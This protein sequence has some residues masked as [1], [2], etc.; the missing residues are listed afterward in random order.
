M[1]GCDPV[2]LLVEGCS[3]CGETRRVYIN[4]AQSIYHTGEYVEFVKRF[5]HFGICDI[6]ELVSTSKIL[7]LLLGA[8]VIRA[9]LLTVKGTT[10][11]I[12]I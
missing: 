5:A 2:L 7:Q 6:L 9:I 10:N 11:Y 8:P 12:C 4:N 3:L 1:E